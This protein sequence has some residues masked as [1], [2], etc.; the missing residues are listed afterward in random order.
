MKVFIALA[1]ALTLSGC[2]GSTVNSQYNPLTQPR[3][4][5]AEST[6]KVANDA[7]IIYLSLRQCRKSEASA[8]FANKCR[9]YASSLQLQTA[10]QRI[11]SAFVTARKCYVGASTTSDC[12]A[13]I[14]AAVSVY[15]N[16]VISITG[17]VQ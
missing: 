8:P 14:E 6:Y 2:A 4:Y 3:M 10:S 7:A 16:K 17:S 15:Y 5:A 11:N 1:L 9:T 13:I 12:A